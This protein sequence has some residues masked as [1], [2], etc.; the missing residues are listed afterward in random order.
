LIFVTEREKSGDQVWDT[1]LG[2]ACR[3]LV[4]GIVSFLS[5]W[6]FNGE[7]SNIRSLSW[8]K[9][10]DNYF[11]LLIIIGAMGEKASETIRRL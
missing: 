2:L 11:I 8:M 1:S 9:R 3:G 7:M 5:N 6:L 4:A 10:I